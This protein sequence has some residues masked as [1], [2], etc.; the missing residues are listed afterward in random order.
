[1]RARKLVSFASGVGFR[2]FGQAG[3]RPPGNPCKSTSGMVI[4]WC[5]R[6]IRLPGRTRPT[7]LV[8]KEPMMGGLE[9]LPSFSGKGSRP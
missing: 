1:M 3:A 7:P 6:T 2:L 8:L 5:Y 4:C 9:K